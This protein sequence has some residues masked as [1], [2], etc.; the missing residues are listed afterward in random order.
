MKYIKQ[1]LL[2]LVCAL[3]VLAGCKDDWDDRTSLIDPSLCDTDLWE[4]I[5]EQGNLSMFKH[6]L[7]LTGY[8]QQ[9]SADYD[10]TV[11]TVFAPTDDVFEAAFRN[12]DLVKEE[13]L[14]DIDG[15]KD[16]LNRHIVSTMH[17]G[18]LGLDPYRIKT[19]DGRRLFFAP[20][21]D[22]SGKMYVD[23][24]IA[25]NKHN[26]LCK[27][28]VIHT[29]TNIIPDRGNVWET[30][31]K[32]LTSAG[33]P[34]Q[35]LNAISRFDYRVMDTASKLIGYVGENPIYDTLWVD[36][37]R[38]MDFKDISNEDTVYTYVVLN[39]EG[40]IPLAVKYGK[41]YKN[42]VSALSDSLII[43][44]LNLDLIF[45]GELKLDAAGEYESVT[46]VKV[47]LDPS[48]I[49][50]IE[51]ASNGYVY[52]MRNASITFR[53]NK[54]KSII[55]E[56]E[57]T[58]YRDA[59]FGP[60]ARYATLIDGDT[61]LRGKLWKK[62]Y[63]TWA[64][65]N[66][67]LN[68][69]GFYREQGNNYDPLSIG[70]DRPAHYSM[71]TKARPQVFSVPYAFYWR[72]GND[73]EKDQNRRIAQRIYVS[74]PST[75]EREVSMRRTNSYLRVMYNE[76]YTQS[77][78]D[79]AAL[80]PSLDAGGVQTNQD[81][82]TFAF[83]ASIQDSLR[84]NYWINNQYSHDTIPASAV[85]TWLLANNRFEDYGFQFTAASD[86]PLPGR[87]SVYVYDAQQDTTI[88]SLLDNL[89]YV[90]DFYAEYQ[91]SDT[92]PERL[93]Y[94]IG[95]TPERVSHIAGYDEEGNE[96]VYSFLLC[97]FPDKT[98]GWKDSDYYSLQNSKFYPTHEQQLLKTYA[99]NNGEYETWSTNE[100][101]PSYNRHEFASFGNAT[102]LITRNFTG[103]GTSN[104]FQQNA[105]IAIDYIRLEPN[106]DDIDE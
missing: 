9:M 56:G 68:L 20:Q 78:P 86:L 63:R 48:D 93:A 54:V 39:D 58:D 4:E 22:A 106:L 103:V 50:S 98:S 46:G 36:S 21:P 47:K 87:D 94:L 83:F 44:N 26:I 49:V 12:G 69:G 37:N 95:Q 75:K 32:Q 45:P 52:R 65:G 3:M 70:G 99:Y 92:F 82:E 2:A 40:Y 85:K 24:D 74:S 11:L 38:I 101:D 5:C 16:F 55:V 84:H 81:R 91:A 80:Y 10:F 100:A 31:A 13:F 7:T 62:K 34:L 14:A 25:I 67:V 17:L 59:N 104:M 79:T 42:P 29:I 1:Y 19:W 77:F 72:M 97:A 6:I 96:F 23:G 28:G 61:F 88:A 8:A 73:I 27:N 71:F 35:L 66:Y 89:Q 33:D 43:L 18:D 76:V 30:A 51:R 60:S 105:Y 41:I 53:N 57:D 90:K 15:L 64:S 102:L